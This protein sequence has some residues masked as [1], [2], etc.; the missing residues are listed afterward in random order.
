L[1]CFLSL[2]LL[3][4]SM[5]IVRS[6]FQATYAIAFRRAIPPRPAHNPMAPDN[7]LAREVFSMTHFG[8][9][10]AHSSFE[11]SPVNTLSV[12][13][14]HIPGILHCE[15]GEAGMVAREMGSIDEIATIDKQRFGWLKNSTYDG[16]EGS[17]RVTSGIVSWPE[18]RI[19]RLTPLPFAL[20]RQSESMLRP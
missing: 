18:M 14:S 16:T 7:D 1:N 4:E 6:P 12:T 15:Q 19:Y 10:Y 20:F 11:L 13:R 9:E 5:F 17:L 8:R 3:P 2:L